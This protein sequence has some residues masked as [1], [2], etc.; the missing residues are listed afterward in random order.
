MNATPPSSLSSLGALRRS[1][2]EAHGMIPTMLN[3][4]AWV[5]RDAA[6]TADFYSRI[7]GMELASTVMDDA[8]P[9]TGDPYPYFH[10]FFR[11]R[12]GST[13]AFFEVPGLPAPAKAS[14]PAYDVFNHL[15]MQVDGRAEVERWAAW[16]KENGVDVIGPID[17]KGLILSIYFHDPDGYRLELTTPLDP[18]W[19]RHESQASADLAFWTETKARA[20]RE[21]RDVAQTMIEAIRDVRRRYEKA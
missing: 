3:H 6:A 1:A 7:L 20:L 10:I 19:N 13:L 2:Q 21:G 17:H 18:Q 8:V 9:S 16:L 15:A 11:M 12:D 5:C 14:H 4:A